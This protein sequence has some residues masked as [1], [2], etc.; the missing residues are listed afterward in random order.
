MKISTISRNQ[1]GAQAPRD[2]SKVI[3]FGQPVKKVYL[4]RVVDDGV[5]LSCLSFV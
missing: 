4:N 1:W 2:E 3:E 5:E